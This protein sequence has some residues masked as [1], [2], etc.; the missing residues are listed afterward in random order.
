VGD[1]A[2][3]DLDELIESELF[4]AARP[5]ETLLTAEILQRHGSAVAAVLFYGSCL[6]RRTSEG[7]L[8]FYVLVD[9]YRAAYRSRLLAWANAALPPNVFYLEIESEIGTLRAKY[10]VISLRDFENGA[11]LGGLRSGIWAR[12][13]QPTLAVQVRDAPAR[14]A[15]AGAV[16]EAVL[17]SVAQALPLLP[18]RAGSIRFNAEEL[19]QQAFRETYSSELRPEDP[20]TIR[21]LYR[22]D[23]KRY[24]R[25]ARAA[26]ARLQR[27]G[28]L[29]FDEASGVIEGLQTRAGRGWSIRRPL[30]K[31][32]YVVQLLKTTA[33]F[34]DWL[35]YA[36]W[37][38]ERHTGTRI[39]PS[40]RQRRHPLL[41]GWP[42][43]FRVLWRRDLR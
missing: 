41:C 35:P 16:A 12:F 36:L 37:K 19:W 40:E 30:A 39:I 33:T 18:A 3:D 2:R 32:I 15:V 20:E 17:T 11:R 24:D 28:R 27:C 6:R 22:A 5:P 29:R 23:P 7:V 14:A 25:A 13:C 4:Q 21:N 8:D 9:N 1:S 34:G 26:L 10:A 31:L 43:L 42:L 38:L